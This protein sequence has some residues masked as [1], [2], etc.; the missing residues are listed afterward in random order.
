VINSTIIQ[1]VDESTLRLMD[2]S[3]AANGK[4]INNTSVYGCGYD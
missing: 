4:E 1:I 2:D 3:K